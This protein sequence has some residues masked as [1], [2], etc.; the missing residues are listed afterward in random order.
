MLVNSLKQN[1]TIILNNAC[2]ST[3]FIKLEENKLKS[4]LPNNKKNK[5]EICP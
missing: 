4:C 3:V 5:P 1:I 2:R